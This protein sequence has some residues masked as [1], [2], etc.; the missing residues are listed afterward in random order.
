MPRGTLDKRIGDLQEDFLAIVDLV[1]RAI[2]RSIQALAERDMELAQRIIDEDVIINQAQR[3]IEEECLFLIAT[4]QPLASDL[5]IITSPTT[6]GLHL[7]RC[8]GG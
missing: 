2:D 4:Q 6:G 1:D 8:P 3:D 5:R 7:P